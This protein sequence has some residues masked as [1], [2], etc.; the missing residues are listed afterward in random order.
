MARRS[1]FEQIGLFDEDYFLYFEEVD[2]MKEAAKANLEVWHNPNA[3]VIHIGGG[4]T[5][6]K[7]ARAQSG[8][9]PPY[10]YDSWRRY[11]VKHHGRLGACL[12]ASCWLA[13]RSLFNL[14][15][16][17]RSSNDQG[18]GPVASDLIWRALIP[19]LANGAKK[20]S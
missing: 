14:K 8:R 6:I 15:R 3:R 16:M 4:A 11:F 7:D 13:G 20:T 17:V 19:A 18:G 10:W 2:L 12:A 9:L 5:N 1:V